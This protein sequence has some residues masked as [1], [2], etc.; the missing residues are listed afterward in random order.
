MLNSSNLATPKAVFIWSFVISIVSTVGF[1]IVA[2]KFAT[3]NA[4][5]DVVTMLLVLAIAIS[6][7]AYYG[8]LGVLAHRIGRSAIVWV[9]LTFILS[10]IGALVAFPW[11]LNLVG[12]HERRSGIS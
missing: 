7:I 1:F 9:G 12:E 3:P 5:L 6:G 2:T 8:S 11:M 10:P 4:P